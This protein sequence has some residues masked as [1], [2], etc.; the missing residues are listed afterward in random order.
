MKDEFEELWKDVKKASKK[1]KRSEVVEGVVQN[2][3]G[4]FPEPKF[5]GG[6]IKSPKRDRSAHMDRG[7][8][9]GSP[10]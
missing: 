8:E 4:S 9:D 1:H 3:D 10:E 2:D 5:S 7:I 6:V